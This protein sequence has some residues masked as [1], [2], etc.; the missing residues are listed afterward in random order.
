[1]KNNRISPAVET[2]EEAKQIWPQV[3]L[4]KRQKDLT[5]QKINKLICLYPSKIKNSVKTFWVCQCD[6]GKYTIG[7]TSSII[8]NRKKSCGCEVKKIR[9]NLTGQKIDKLL[10]LGLDEE[11]ESQRLPGI[12]RKW[13]CQCDCG[14]ICSYYENDLLK[15][16]ITHSCGC[17][18][19]ENRKQFGNA[20]DWTGKRQGLLTVLECLGP[21]VDK[22]NN[23]HKY[24][25]IWRCQ[26]DC[27]NIKNIK[28]SN[29]SQVKSCGCSSGHY[30][31]DLIGSILN[32]LSIEFEREYKFNNLKDKNYLRFDY[33]LIKNN[34]VIGLIEYQ[35]QQHFNPKHIY[36]KESVVL[37][38]Q[39]KKEYCKNNNIPLLEIYYYESSNIK[40]KIIKFLNGL[41]D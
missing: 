13:K 20:T 9:N 26:C 35:G 7:E 31:E 28:S 36:Y 19:K 38:D 27:G 24:D 4:S 21:I 30:W 29:L 34:S 12:H 39:I 3:S 22:E 10:V 33:A 16:K 23:S 11:F 8:R 18:Q 1:M 32:E 41:E 6:C 15:N 25:L 37:H 17:V 14:N 5:N 40:E 2:F